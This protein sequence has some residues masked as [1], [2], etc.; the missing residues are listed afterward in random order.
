MILLGLAYGVFADRYGRARGLALNIFSVVIGV[1]WLQMIRT[2]VGS[3]DFLDLI[4]NSRLM[5]V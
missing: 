2:F 1:I 3:A 5:N 4:K